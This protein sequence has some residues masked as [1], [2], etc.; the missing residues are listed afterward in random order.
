MANKTSFL[1]LLLPELSEYRDIWNEPVN[2]NFTKIDTAIDDITTEVI[3]SRQGKSSLLAYLQVSMNNDGSLKPTI[4]VRQARNSFVFGHRDPVT[5]VLYSLKDRIRKADEEIWGAREGQTSLLEELAFREHQITGMVVVGTKNVN[6]YPTWLSSSAANVIVNG[7]STPIWFMIDGKLCRVRTQENVAITGAVGMKYVYAQYSATG[8]VIVDGD[9]GT[10]PPASA[11][12]TTS[13]DVNSEATL[14]TDVTRDFTTENVEAG[15]VLTLLT[16]SDAGVYLVKEVAPG[17]IV[18]QLKIQGLFPVGGLSSID[19][20]ITDKVGVTLGFDTTLTPAIGKLYIGEAYFD[21]VAVATIPSDTVSTRALHFKDTFVGEWRAIDVSSPTTFEEIYQHGLRST[22]LDVSVQVS[23][24]NDN[25]Q[26]VEELS[27]GQAISTLSYTPAN[28]TLA[29]G[30]GTLAV[31][32]GTMAVSAVGL[33][34]G[35]QTITAQPT[36]T[37]S[38]ALTG[39]PTL[40]GTV[41]GSLSGT[42][43]MSRS[44]AINWDV[45]KVRVKNV[46]SGVFY[47]DYS[48]TIRTAGYLRV[49]VRKRG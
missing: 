44:V 26:P 21:G 13:V 7:S 27:L 9:S 34:A 30:V 36:L 43:Q 35:S 40:S 46:H 15:D 25:S 28:G 6:G 12:G 22:I 5:D 23:Q 8:V 17:A 3:N 29:I 19:Y 1:E 33:S 45:N 14:F 32:T 48:G 10:P 31:G 49:V 20:T 47:K 42:V 39:A 11:N 4:E 38:P 37:G 24:A 41:G 2:D 18:T 16:G